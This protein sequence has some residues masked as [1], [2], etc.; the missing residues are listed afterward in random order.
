MSLT[1]EQIKQMPLPKRLQY[2][3]GRL[4]ELRQLTWA[5]FP[6]PPE[7]LGPIYDAMIEAATELGTIDATAIAPIVSDAEKVV[8]AAKAIRETFDFKNATLM[9]GESYKLRKSEE[10]AI[11]VLQAAGAIPAEFSQP[12]VIG[13]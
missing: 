6:S 10:L 9:A 2:L 3:A 8:A 12:E 4:E 5:R 1:N 11:V 13:R 7:P